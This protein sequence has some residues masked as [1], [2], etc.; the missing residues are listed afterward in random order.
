MSMYFCRYLASPGSASIDCIFVKMVRNEMN[1][2][3]MRIMATDSTI[4]CYFDRQKILKI[5]MTIIMKKI[6][7]MPLLRYELLVHS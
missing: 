1:V 3:M 6:R 2:T 7:S 5:I 4:Y